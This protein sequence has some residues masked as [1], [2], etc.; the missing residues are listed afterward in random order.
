MKILCCSTD[1]ILL[2]NLIHL[3]GKDSIKSYSNI[4]QIKD[5]DLKNAEVILVDLKVS[6]IPDGRRFPTPLIALTTVPVFKEAVI[7]M[8]IG[9]K[10]YGNRKMRPENIRLAIESVISGQIWLPPEIVNQLI[11]SVGVEGTKV[12]EETSILDTLST[13]EKEVASYVAKGMSNQ[14]MADK[15]FVTLRTVK[16]HLSSIYD[17]TGLRNRLELGLQVKQTN[18]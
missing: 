17:K 8:Q 12:K 2:D 6:K 1:N 14:E 7:L 9:V 15:M 16:A 3:Y 18:L 13:R 5:S 11:S 10:G 4:N